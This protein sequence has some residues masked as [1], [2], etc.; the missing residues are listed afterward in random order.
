MSIAA[1]DATS[2]LPA[3]RGGHVLQSWTELAGRL[4]LGVL[5]LLSGLG[6]I[7][8]Y[9]AT[10]GYMSA[11]GVPTGLLPIVIGL[12]VL[13]A[14]LLF[15]GWKTRIVAFLLAG[16]SLLSATI[17]H[18]DFADQVQLVMFLKNVSIA[19]GLLLVVA[20]GAGPYSIDAKQRRS[21]AA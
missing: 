1:H 20:N 12:E 17:F 16:F 7:T 21:A 5:F 9:A 11:M 8:G 10:A 15:V 3:R 4:F 13:G 6:K 2:P 19:G 18:A 14:L